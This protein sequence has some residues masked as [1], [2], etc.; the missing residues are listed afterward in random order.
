M[1][2]KVSYP[3]K[4]DLCQNPAKEFSRCEAKRVYGACFGDLCQ[5]GCWKKRHPVRK[6]GPQSMEAKPDILS[7]TLV[8]PPDH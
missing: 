1:G 8:Q 7:G 5:P 2:T 3:R 6:G 4:G